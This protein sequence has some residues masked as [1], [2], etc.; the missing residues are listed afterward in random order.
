MLEEQSGQQNDYVHVPILNST[1]NLEHEDLSK[2]YDVVSQVLNIQN[3]HEPQSHL[4]LIVYEGTLRVPSDQVIDTM[5]ESLAK[6]GI[7]A[8]FRHSDGADDLYLVRIM[9]GRFDPQPRPWII[10]AILFVLT[11]FS[12]LFVGATIQGGL[13]N[14][15][16]TSFDDLNIQ[17]WDGW[18][19]A[20]SL[21]LILGAHEL[22]HYFA[23]RYHKVSVTLPYFIPLPFGFFGTLGAFIQL[24]EPMKNRNTLFDIGV[25]GPLAGLFFAIPVLFLGLMT[26][27]IHPIPEDVL[28]EGNS[29]FYAAAKTV[30]FGH[31]VPDGSEDVFINQFA[32][33]GWVGLFVT[34]LNLVP[35]GQLDGGHVLYSLFGRYARR[36]YVPVIG[37][38]AFLTIFVYPGWALWTL[39]LFFLGRTHAV[40]LDDVTPLSPRR[41]LVG[42]LTILI[43]ILIFIPNP[44]QQS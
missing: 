34:M 4:E 13:D 32:Q 40:P 20:S 17:L 3:T 18:Q 33:A 22:G 1:P 10:N 37:A 21:I 6:L 16:A 41:R 43:F 28:F 7:H 9:N 12:L 35:V 15:D 27:E 19:Y 11:I 25:A 23:A 8:Y 39:L 31:Y 2:I 42:Y 5:D 30:V 44:F 26:S 14:P 24:R 38:L 29:L 36:L